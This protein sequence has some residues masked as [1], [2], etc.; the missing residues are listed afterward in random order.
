MNVLVTGGL[1]FIGSHFVQFQRQHHPGDSVVVLD[2]MTYCCDPACLD[3]L[4][5]DSGL[6]VVRG[7]IRNHDLLRQLFHDRPIDAICNFAAETHV[8]RSIKNGLSFVSTNVGGTAT[9]LEVARAYK[10]KKFV[11][12]ST[13]EVYGALGPDD[14][15]FTEETQLCPRSPYSASKAGADFV[16][17]SYYHT[18]GMNVT[19]TRCSNNFG[20][21]QFPEKFIPLVITRALQNK[22]VPIYGDGMQVRDWLHVSDHCRGVDAAMR[23]GRAGQVYNLGSRNEFRNADMARYI[24]EKLERPLSL[25]QFVKDRPGHDRRYA[26]DFT[27][28]QRELGWCPRVSLADGLEDTLAFYRD[29]PNYG[30]KRQTEAQCIF[31]P[32]LPLP[33]T[34]QAQ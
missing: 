20:P 33:V 10:T 18:H 9:L 1:G 17:L 23:T 8:D 22:S 4:R 30:E 29:N 27:K 16:T 2:A 31:T 32:D 34:F 25:L 19:V 11:Q 14:P 21:R 6:D 24:L 13:D 28:A 3:S 5:G 26:V 7:D 15:P 12:I